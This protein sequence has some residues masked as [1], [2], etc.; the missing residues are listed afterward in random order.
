MATS[1]INAMLTANNP[2]INQVAGMQP[3][4]GWLVGTPTISFPA[5]A[6]PPNS[7]PYI[8][9][10][11]QVTGL[12]SFFARIWGNRTATVT[13]TATAEAYN[14][15]NVQSFTPIAPKGVKPWL[16]ANSDPMQGG[17]QFINTTT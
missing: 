10:K 15:A 14:P 11:L 3:V 12:P 2:P 8:T 9:V 5:S 16:V 1:A 4:T 6:N 7:N 13:A 17:A